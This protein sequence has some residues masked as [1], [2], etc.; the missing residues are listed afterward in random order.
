MCTHL[1]AKHRLNRGVWLG[2]EGD[3]S[4]DLRV[5]CLSLFFGWEFG[6]QIF[7]LFDIVQT[8]VRA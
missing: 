3:I 7:S 1:W 6:D 2:G 8:V 4:S 5:Y